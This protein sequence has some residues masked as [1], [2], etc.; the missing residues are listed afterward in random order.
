[1]A[2][3]RVQRRLAAILAADVVGYSR[4]MGLDEGGTLSRL[5]TL[6]QEIFA[7]KTKQYG[8]R[9]FKT[10]GDGALVEFNSAVD[11]VKSAVDIQE[12][13]AARNAGA[14]DDQKILL[15]IG[16]SLG[17]V[18]VE[19]SDLY[20]NSVNVASR[21]EGLAEPGGICVS[22]NVHEH[23]GRSLDVIFED[24]GDQS[25]KNIVQPVRCYR[26]LLE[27]GKTDTSPD[28]DTA[29]ALPDR[30]AVAVLPF[31][32]LSGDAEQE[33]F[34][35]GL[36]EDII[37]ALSRLR[38]LFVIARNSTFAYKGKAVDIK[39]VGRELGVRY[40]LEGSIRKAGSRI[41]VTAQLIEA[42][43][44]NHIWAERYD[45][46][47]ADIFDL[48]DELTEAISAQV[49]A[50]LAGS[51]RALAYKKPTTDLDTWE[52][53]QRGMWHFCKYTKDDFVEARRLL[54]LASERAPNFANA[55]AGLTV[56]GSSEITWG[57]RQDRAR[58]LEQGLRHAEKAVALDERDGNN[59][60]ALG[61]ACLVL[62]DGERAI[63]SLEKS[64]DLNPSSAASHYGL[65][66][67][68]YW[69]GRAE[70]ALPRLTLAIRLSPHDPRL[71][72]FHAIRSYA[73][74]MLD[75]FDLAI[76]DAK[77]AI[78]SK[79]DIFGPHM[80]LA[81]AYSLSG[82]HDEARTAYDRAH[83][84][85]PELSAADFASLM[86]TLHPPYLEI[87]L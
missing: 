37:T 21:M 35:D 16:I 36:T 65:G 51:E 83:K 41:R 44:G 68:L 57:F 78:Q 1:M 55:Y 77:A 76:V 2:E 40:V 32:N 25:V 54:L 8:G 18:I 30:L 63:P 59:Q 82:R 22:G 42:E 52:L 84:L 14:D 34:A 64:V 47:L 69:F 53:Y 17:D 24:M 49:D 3:E 23:I 70:E 13:L 38:W 39:Q 45:R 66:M 6:R 71:W 61:I 85:N 79:R 80:A 72:L 7:P 73:H 74:I 60:F 46:E 28:Q 11:A 19:G 86:G 48:Q 15:R 43:S 81:A 26:V 4:M 87:I 62:G 20:G 27:P 75:E 5:K 50:E 67:A 58:V 9:T 12:A 10:T 31:E 56:I 29:P 33:Y